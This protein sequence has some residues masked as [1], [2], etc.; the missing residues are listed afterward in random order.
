[1]DLPHIYVSEMFY[2]ALM[3]GL[4][5]AVFFQIVTIVYLFWRDRTQRRNERP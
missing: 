4:T 5:T 2:N 1:M 3:A